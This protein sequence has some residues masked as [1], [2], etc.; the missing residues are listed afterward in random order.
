M[1]TLPLLAS[2]AV[3]AT[4]AATAARAQFPNFPAA[5]RVLGAADFT[6]GGTTAATPAGLF[7]PTGLAIDP[8]TG[9]LFVAAG[10]HHRIL[11]F[12]N[13]AS[14]SNGANAEVA[15]GQAN[16]SGTSFGNT[17]T[18]FNGP[19]GVHVDAKGRLWVADFSNHRVLMFLG[20]S[21]LPGFGS[22]PDLVLGQPNFITVTSGIS[23]VK[24]DFPIGVFVDAADNLWV[25]EN[26]NHRV[27]KFAAVSSLANG[28]AATAVLGQPDF[29][30]KTPITSA[31]GMRSPRSVTVD[32]GG[33]LWVADQF[34]HRVLRYDAAASLANGA[35]ATAVLGQPDFITDPTGTTAQTMFQPAAVL[36]DG[37]GT[38]YV[39]D[40]FNRRVLLFKRAA[41]K[42]NGAA[43]DGVIGQPDFTTGTFATTARKL[44][45]PSSGLAMDGAGRL[46]VADTSSNRVLRYSPDRTAAPPKITSRVPRTT[47]RAT[48]VV[49]GTASDTSGVKEVRHRVGRGAF[50]KAA[51]TT[52]WSF[53][54]RLRPGQNTIAIVMVDAAGNVSRAKT[55]RVTLRR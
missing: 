39:T 51:G 23:A 31:T 17:A 14:L 34:N 53:T 48:L 50:R 11:R 4:T 16:F 9:K 2:L 8:L 36:V 55:V 18:K 47:T 20:A 37:V 29:I 54:A 45:N 38:L 40:Q 43:A 22:T 33:R 21:T 1:K 19:Y 28:A 25:A 15:F 5:D 27:L 44:T 52:A 24:M 32:G 30:T 42:V 3:L 46:W 6:T 41:S 7:F 13:V 12:P 10:N 26:S 35:S 49:K